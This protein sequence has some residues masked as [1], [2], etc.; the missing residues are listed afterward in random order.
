VL[1]LPVFVPNEYLFKTHA[2]KVGSQQA[3]SSNENLAEEQVSPKGSKNMQNTEGPF[4][5]ATSL[6]E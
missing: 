4:F 3:K 1:E 5:P 6:K 2:D